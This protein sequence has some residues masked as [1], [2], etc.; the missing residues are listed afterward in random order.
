MLAGHINFCFHRNSQP[1]D[2]LLFLTGQM[3]IEDAC[4]QIRRAADELG[5]VVVFGDAHW[6]GRIS[7]LIFP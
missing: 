4:N 5:L 3:E 7:L 2:I 1:G 6:R